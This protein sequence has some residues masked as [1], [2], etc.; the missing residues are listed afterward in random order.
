[1]QQWVA[2][3]RAC[4]M[5]CHVSGQSSKLFFCRPCWLLVSFLLIWKKLGVKRISAP[6]LW[7]FD[8]MFSSP[9]HLSWS[10]DW[11]KYF[12]DPAP[13]DWTHLCWKEVI[14]YNVYWDEPHLPCLL[15]TGSMS[16]KIVDVTEHRD[17]HVKEWSMW[18]FILKWN[19]AP[20]RTSRTVL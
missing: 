16:S 7:R 20:L 14:S 17:R 1:M 9:A 6:H 2:Q 19:Y 13:R 18:I 4:Y 15:A 8:C 3:W 5:S 11:G 10:T 12:A